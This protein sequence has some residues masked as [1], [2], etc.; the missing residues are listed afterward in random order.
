LALIFQKYSL[1]LLDS[2]LLKLFWFINLCRY[3]PVLKICGQQCPWPWI[4]NTWINTIYLLTKTVYY[5]YGT[6]EI[7]LLMFELEMVKV[8]RKIVG[9]TWATWTKGVKLVGIIRVEICSK[10]F[11][12][13]ITA[14]DALF[15]CTKEINDWC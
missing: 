14:F 1:Q 12:Q 2:M 7:D 11:F 3:I 6:T 15:S 4:R 8:N 9:F 13:K 10:V 5:L